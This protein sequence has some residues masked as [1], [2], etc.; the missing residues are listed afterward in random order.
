MAKQTIFEAAL[1]LGYID[2][3]QKAKAEQYKEEY[4]LSDDTVIRETKILSDESIVKLYSDVY[5]IAKGDVKEVEDM[6][7]MQRLNPKEMRNLFFFPVKKEEK[8]VIYTALPSN[9]VYA[10]DMLREEFEY[11]DDFLYKVISLKELNAF[12]SKAFE[13]KN[14]I[15][16]NFNIEGETVKTENVYNITEEDSSDV[17]NLINKILFDAVNGKVSDVHLEP[18]KDKLGVRFRE[19]GRLYEYINID[20]SIAQQLIN[21]IKTMANLDVN[22]NRTIQ[23]GSCQLEIFEKNVDLR[24]SVAPALYGENIVIRV[25]DQSRV[26]LDITKIG[27]SKENE[28]LFKKLIKR[29]Q[30]MILLTGPTSSGKSTSLY[31]AISELNTKDRCIITFEDPIE[32]KIPGIV[33]VQINP[34]MKVTFPEALKSGLRQD[35]EVALVGEIRDGETASIAFDAANTGHMVFS[36]LHA[37][38]AAASLTRLTNLGVDPYIISSSLVAVINQRLVRRLCENCK[39]E[40]L[41]EEDSPYRKILGCG[42]HPMTLF[43]AKGCSACK[44]EGYDDRIAIHEVL[45]FNDEIGRLLAKGASDS[46]IERAAINSGMKKIHIDGI[47]KAIKGLTTIEDIIPFVPLDEL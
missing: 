19:K 23:D 14:E 34:A 16:K 38:T 43:R 13:G 24:I 1:E 11:R 25:L 2:F 22:N 47:E 27:F 32:Y 42:N 26:P 41:L 8:I 17:V 5:G 31:S 4:G 18:Q 33:Q 39:E 7:L 9:L 3:V 45:V 30:G 46:E 6:S 44:S 28:E 12:L 36:T 21:R 35:I 15:L 40:Y 20:H 29:P 37:Q 10:E